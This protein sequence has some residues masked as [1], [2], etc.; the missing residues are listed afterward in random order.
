MPGESK[1]KKVE[2]TPK[3]IFFKCKFCGQTKPFCELVVLRQYYPQLSACKDCAKG[4][5]TTEQSE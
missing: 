5:P 1:I 2:P 3:E 4:K